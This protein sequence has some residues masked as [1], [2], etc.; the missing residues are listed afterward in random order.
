MSIREAIFTVLLCYCGWY[1]ARAG[2]GVEFI[3][4]IIFWE[5]GR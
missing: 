5:M 3:A 4:G 1:C 2:V